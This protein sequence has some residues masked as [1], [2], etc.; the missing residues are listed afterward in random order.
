MSWPEKSEQTA[1]GQPPLQADPLFGRDVAFYVFRLPIWREVQQEAID[2]A[3][4]TKEDLP[5]ERAHEQARPE[6]QQD[7]GD[8][9]E[10]DP[11]VEVPRPAGEHGRRAAVFH[12]MLQTENWRA[13]IEELIERAIDLAGQKARTAK[14]AVAETKVDFTTMVRGDG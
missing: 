4:V 12:A 1:D 14:L 6:R 10:R 2:H 7:R 5:R 8:V 13:G 11:D 9:Q 3:G